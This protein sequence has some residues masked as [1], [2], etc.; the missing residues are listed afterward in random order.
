MSPATAIAA[1]GEQ[2]GPFTPTSFVYALSSTNGDVNY[3]ISGVPAWLTA[4][5]S[6]GTA[7]SSSANVTFSIN[8][9][10]AN[11]LTPG[12]Y[13]ATVSFTSANGFGTTTRTATLTV[14]PPRTLQVSPA[15]A[16]ASSGIEGGPF[17][18]SSFA[19]SLSSAN[20]NVNYTISG[21]PA[22]LSA[23][24]TSGTATS[25]PQT[26]T[27]TVTAAAN[28]LAPGTYS[29]TITFTSA[30]TFGTTT[31]TATLTVNP[32]PPQMQVSAG[33][34]S[35]SG[36]RG[37]PFTPASGTFTLS[38]VNQNL[39][40]AVTGLPNWLSASPASG[41]V[42]TTAQTTV[43]LSPSAAAA[44]LSPGTYV[45]T[46]N[47]VNTTNGIGNASRSVTL[48]VG[49][50]SLVVQESVAG[51]DHA[52]LQARTDAPLLC[53]PDWRVLEAPAVT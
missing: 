42:T 10:A 36:G 1:A 18:P 21:M 8:T 2:G 22:W 45:A 25:T 39:Q 52:E 40:F 23:S 43:T 28:A 30:S 53:A 44:T 7:T 4:S 31:R 9:A 11:A 15:T 35:F 46:V 24:A 34:L 5:A 51:L 3:T 29:S 50:S 38:A 13:T 17:T 19:Y 20:G 37:G 16:I 26:V 6:S 41:T 33:G 14:N 47:F 49:T 48:T 12:T 27:F 32:R